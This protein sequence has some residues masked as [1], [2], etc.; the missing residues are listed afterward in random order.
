MLIV[1]FKTIFTKDERGVPLNWKSVQ[2][3]EI[4][5]KYVDAK[6]VSADLM[7][8]LKYF[9]IRK[10]GTSTLGNKFFLLIKILD[11]K[12]V[13]PNAT[14]EINVTKLDEEMELEYKEAERKHVTSSFNLKFLESK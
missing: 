2:A 6:K 1:R 3:E 14:W 5:R 8:Y 11:K 4:Q 13:L 12:A 9:G 7:D 10:R